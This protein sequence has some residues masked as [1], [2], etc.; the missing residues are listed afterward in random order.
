M[1]FDDLHSLSG[2][3]RELLV[4]VQS[5]DRKMS[6]RRRRKRSTDY[7]S[8]TL[9]ATIRPRDGDL[10]LRRRERRELQSVHMFRAAARGSA[11]LLGEASWNDLNAI[12]K[13]T[14]G[15]AA[16]ALRSAVQAL[17]DVEV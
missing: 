15:E 2:A 10:E 14:T 6:R 13:A 9:N 11:G 12:G 1:V 8:D 16:S 7:C 3:A 4:K 5:A 17:Q